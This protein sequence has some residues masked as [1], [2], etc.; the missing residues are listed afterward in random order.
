MSQWI[1]ARLYVKILKAIVH[2]IHCS[3][4][5]KTH[6]RP[7]GWK[8]VSL[9]AREGRE[10]VQLPAISRLKR[11]IFLCSLKS[12]II[13]PNAC[14]LKNNPSDCLV[15]TRA[16]RLRR[17]LLLNLD[18][19]LDLRLNDLLRTTTLLRLLVVT[20]SIHSLALLLALGTIALC[21]GIADRHAVP[22][23]IH[24]VLECLLQATDALDA[25]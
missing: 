9:N 24:V 15:P 13:S 2:Y 20:I 1:A 5:R 6:K 17:S 4:L 23:R 12:I 10:P 22:E 25:A 11:I 16:L 8:N 19:G 21:L 18:L 14:H 3:Y 7:L